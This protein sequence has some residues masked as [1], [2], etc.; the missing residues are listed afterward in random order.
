MAQRTFSFAYNKY[1]N[2]DDE[3]LPGL[4][5]YALYKRA[6]VAYL[7]NYNQVNGKDATEREIVNWSHDHS[8]PDKIE[9]FRLQAL[10][11]VE[12]YRQQEVMKAEPEIRKAIE[13]EHLGSVHAK[14]SSLTGA[15][16]FWISVGA[17]VV[18]SLI[19]IPLAGLLYIGLRQSNPLGLVN[20]GPTGQPAKPVVQK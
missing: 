10:R 9:L 11:S 6:K 19:W 3:D 2:G 18:A 14:V 5:A 8:T 7:Q 4:I 20:D 17:G 1:V 15:K 16:A 12:R 13:A